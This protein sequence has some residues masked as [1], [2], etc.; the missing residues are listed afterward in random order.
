MPSNRRADMVVSASGYGGGCFCPKT[1]DDGGGL[2]GFFDGNLGLLAA[3]GSA[4]LILYTTA[5]NVMRRKRSITS[6][7]LK[8]KIKI[9]KYY[10]NKL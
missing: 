9:K 10:Q 5:L 1:G 3:A 8:G 6:K 7:V 2:G 4:F